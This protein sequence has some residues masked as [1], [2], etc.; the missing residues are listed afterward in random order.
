MGYLI[1]I[2]DAI[3]GVVWSGVIKMIAL[4]LVGGFLIKRIRLITTND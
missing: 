2:Q 1:I 4:M 3:T